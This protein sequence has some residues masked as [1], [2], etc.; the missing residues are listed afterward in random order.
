MST[1]SLINNVDYST[2]MDRNIN[3]SLNSTEGTIIPEDLSYVITINTP[4]E[5]LHTSNDMSIIIPNRLSNN[6]YLILKINLLIF[7]S[8]VIILCILYL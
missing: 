3:L 1:E 4:N 6:K 7:F 5:E 8:S 2:K